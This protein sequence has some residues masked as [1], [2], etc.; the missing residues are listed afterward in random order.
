MTNSV[1]IGDL[2]AALES[3]TSSLEDCALVIARDAYP[4]LRAETYLE[5][6][7]ALADR[8]VER[9]GRD[10]TA[11]EATD[12]LR[13]TLYAEAGLSGNRE[14]FHDPRNSYLNDVLDRGLGIPISLAVVILAVSRR[15]GVLAEGIGFPGHFLVRIGGPGGHFADPFEDLTVLGAG[16]LE[17]LAQRYVGARAKV[18]LSHLEPQS[19]KAI[20]VRMLNNLRSIH[21]HRKDHRSALVVCDRLVELD[22]GA[23]AVRD[24]GLHALALG[25]GRVAEADLAR[26]LS[27]AP[28]APDRKEVEA[29]LARASTLTAL[30]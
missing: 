9:L 11:S 25:A 28:T 26:Y 21:E 1:R 22:V 24:R 23:P 14:A 2:R 20:L 13:A 5:R 15:A 10:S 19:N 16:D 17:R 4:T 7:D 8:V 6:L 30:N 29:A 27:L 18:S 12:A 3:E